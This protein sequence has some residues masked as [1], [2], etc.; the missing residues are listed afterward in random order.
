MLPVLRRLSVR[1]L[2]IGCF[3]AG[4][5]APL[6]DAAGGR[7]LSSISGGEPDSSHSSV[8]GTVSLKRGQ[9]SLCTGTLVAPNL[10]VTARH[11]VS[12]VASAEVVCGDSAFGEPID[13]SDYIATN[14]TEIETSRAWYEALRIDVPA[15]GNDTCGFDIALVTL[16]ENVAPSVATPTVPRIDRGV[17]LGEEYVAVGY[18][19]DE[20]GNTQGRSVLT[21]LEV[22]CEP[23][24][25]GTGVRVTEFR[26][27]AG[28]CEGDS[29]GPALDLDGKLVGVVSRG[30]EQCSTPVYG[31]ISAWREL[32][33]SVA[34]DAAAAGGYTAP[35]WATTGQ[36]DPPTQPVPPA[37]PPP[38]PTV[39]PPSPPPTGTTP[40][41]PAPD[42]ELGG[43]GDACS[44]SNDCQ[45]GFGCYEQNSSTPPF[46]VERCELDA[47]C[48]GSLTCT[49]VGSGNSEASVCLERRAPVPADPGEA[50]APN[51]PD[52]SSATSE[53]GCAIP[54][55]GG[56]QSSRHA[57]AAA[58]SLV[59][60]A[61]FSRRRSTRSAS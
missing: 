42:P 48:G 32:I 20:L 43:Q 5:T 9:A 28:V 24:K 58:L 11:C 50:G 45:R 22:M 26:G 13:A 30:G 38:T 33:Q 14:A 54:S 29:G 18:G 36:S 59:A 6:E 8:F 37:E 7:L 40:G 53:A 15:E 41:A 4:C 17:T 35:F 10:L 46:C 31:S 44:A 16:A 39:T 34:L 12:I 57:L 2:F 52:E 56:A 1:A 51:L 21:G 25:C 47:D 49:S 23:G 55:V 60:L 3:S 61:V 19:I 27:T